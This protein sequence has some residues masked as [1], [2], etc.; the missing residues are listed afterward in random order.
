ML[1]R[2]IIRWSITG[3]ES[4][5]GNVA[6]CTLDLSGILVERLL[7]LFL[8]LFGHFGGCGTC[9][10]VHL[11]ALGFEVKKWSYGCGG[12]IAGESSAICNEEK[13]L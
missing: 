7:L 3:S 1:V 11:P 9:G 2:N 12:Y 6:L 4:Q 5:Q 10:T 8:L 13:L